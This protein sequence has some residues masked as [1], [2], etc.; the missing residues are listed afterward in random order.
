[1]CYDCF[2]PIFHTRSCSC[3]SLHAEAP[4]HLVPFICIYNSL[5]MT[6]VYPKPTAR[7]GNRFLCYISEAQLLS[8][9]QAPILLQTSQFKLALQADS[10]SPGRESDPRVPPNYK[11]VCAANPQRDYV[12]QDGILCGLIISCP[13][14][15]PSNLTLC[16]S[17]PY[18]HPCLPALLA[19]RLGNKCLLLQAFT[20]LG[21]SSQTEPRERDIKS[22]AVISVSKNQ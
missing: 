11:P 7:K 17:V 1:M 9:L 2:Q 18:T 5:P 12:A 8:T 16:W 15:L 13:D 14:R 10:T 19:D 3:S 21:P 20:A 4:P 6:A 22:R